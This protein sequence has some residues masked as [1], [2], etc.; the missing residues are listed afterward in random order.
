[1]GAGLEKYPSSK[2]LQY[3][4][5]EINKFAESIDELKKKTD[6]RK[7]PFHKPIHRPDTMAPQTPQQQA[8][9]ISLDKKRKFPKPKRK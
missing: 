6:V 7:K 2:L 9:V 8:D 3:R 4:R 5:D 1:M